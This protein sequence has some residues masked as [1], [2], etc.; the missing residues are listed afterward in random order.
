MREWLEQEMGVAPWVFEGVFVPLLAFLAVL[1]ARELLLLLV[2]QR[3]EDPE[4]RK[5]WRRRTLWIGLPLAILSAVGASW[6]RQ[7][8][9]ARTLATASGEIV[10]VQTHLGSAT[11][12]TAYTIVLVTFFLIIQRTH[13]TLAAR[14]DDW[15]PAEEGVKVQ[16]A[17]LLS[18]E[19]VRTMLN[20][21]LRLVRAL[22]IFVLFY[23]YIPFILSAIP[24]THELA[25]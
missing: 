13:R 12:V 24:Q 5:V 21:A 6:A 8:R 4:R 25:G 11:K 19:R 20:G 14:I 18:P 23:L 1:L 16:S 15:K 10:E 2:R 7:N 22:L 3:V 17:V 9:I